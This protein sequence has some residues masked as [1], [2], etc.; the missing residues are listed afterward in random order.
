M[1]KTKQMIRLII[2]GLKLKPGDITY[3]L[4][5]ITSPKAIKL[6]RR[7]DLVARVVQGMGVSMEL[8]TKSLSRQAGPVKEFYNTVKFAFPNQPPKWY[9]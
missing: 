5:L 9:Q 8:F 3:H 6:R 2:F 1:V 4:F 7:L